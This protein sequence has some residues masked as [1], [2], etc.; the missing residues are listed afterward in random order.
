MRQGARAALA[1]THTKR[2]GRNAEL[3]RLRRKLNEKNQVIAELTEALLQ[4]KK[5]LSDY[6]TGNG[7]RRR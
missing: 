1:G 3:E 5:G 6:L 4:E 2:D 7:F